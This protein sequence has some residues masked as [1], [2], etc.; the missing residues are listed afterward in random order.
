MDLYSNYDGSMIE[1][2][3]LGIELKLRIVTE[4]ESVHSKMT[5]KSNNSCFNEVLNKSGIFLDFIGIN[6]Y[7]IPIISIYANMTLICK[8]KFNFELTN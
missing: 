4:I 8:C 6:N 3:T 2:F 5:I 1:P 7:L